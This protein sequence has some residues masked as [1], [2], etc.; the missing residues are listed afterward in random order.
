MRTV[1][2]TD[3]PRADIRDAERLGEYGVAT[4]HEALGRVGYLGPQIRPAWAGARVGGTAVTVLCWPGDNLMI[5]VA[6]EQCRPGDV[7]VVATASPSSDGLFG[8]LFATALARR[9]VR[10]VVLGTGVRDVA[11][12]REM[13]FPAW[14]RAVSAQGTVKAT[15]GCVNVPVVLGGQTIHPGDVVVADDD[16][17]LVVPRSDVP[18]ALTAARARVDKEDATRAA[19]R[20]GELGL[21]RYGLRAKLADL[22]IEYVP[23]DEYGR[24]EP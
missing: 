23:Y 10:G 24:G 17:A 18:R 5:H 14:S 11:Q 3:P 4:V 12:L 16:G 2:V 6:V 8:E 20:G 21:D 13:G 19:F 9:G 15:P 22:G 1:V 7:L